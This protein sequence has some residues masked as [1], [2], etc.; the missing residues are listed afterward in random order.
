MEDTDGSSKQYR[1]ASS[2]YL[3]STICMKYNIVIDCA[4]HAPGHGIDVVDGLNA[5]DKRFKDQSCSE[6][7]FLRNIVM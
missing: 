7:Q 6:T 2:L 3:I 4:V 5:A 1:Y